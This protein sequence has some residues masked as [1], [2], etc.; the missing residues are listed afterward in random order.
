M[1]VIPN[2]FY[3]QS[4]GVTSVI[5]VTACGIIET[6]RTHA[7]KIGTV[8]A[9]KNGIL[10]ALHEALIDTQFETDSTIA[11]LRYVPGGAFGSCRYR[12]PDPNDNIAIY[13]RLIDVFKTHNI[14]YVFYN[15]GGDSMDTALKISVV[16]EYLNYPVACIGIPKTID[17]DLPETDSCP[18]FASTAKYIA[19]SVREAAMDIQSMNETST[20]VFVMEVMGRNSGWIAASAALAMSH[21]NDA[22]HMILFPERH[23]S[24]ALFLARV[25]EC[26][27]SH[28]YC[29]IVASEGIRYSDGTFLSSS[30][31]TDAFGHVQLGGTAPLLARMIK[32][33]SGHK[34]HWCVADYLQRSARHLSS[35]VDIEQAYAVGKKA[36]ELALAGDN[37]VMTSIV[38]RAGKTFAWY[39]DKTPLEKVAN[40]EKKLPENFIAANNMHITQACRDYLTPLIQGEGY[41]PYKNGVPD[42]TELKAVMVEKQ[43]P[44]FSF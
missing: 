17:N 29:V 3:A 40:M 36:V 15:G 32:D 26:I 38:R 43:L 18:G 35:R 22:P 21:E 41:P 24:R 1:S 5:N 44:D 28:G 9:G 16:S 37:R 7:D 42:Y 31:S 11:D 6:A 12:L 20:K 34:Y 39:V 14:K 13:Q 2:A 8:F 10:G 25:E 27:Q 23:F 19:T 33:A 4:G 30:R